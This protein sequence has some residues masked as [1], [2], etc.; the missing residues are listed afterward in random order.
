MPTNPNP[1]NQYFSFNYK[2]LITSSVTWKNVI[3]MAWIIFLAL[4]SSMALGGNFSLIF[5][6]WSETIQTILLRNYRLTKGKKSNI[7]SNPRRL[8]VSEE[9][10]EDCK[11]TVIAKNLEY[12]LI[13]YP[14]DI[15]KCYLILKYQGHFI[16]EVPP[17]GMVLD[18]FQSQS[19]RDINT[20][21]RT[22]KT[23]QGEEETITLTA[24]DYIALFEI[25][26]QHLMALSL[27]DLQTSGNLTVSNSIL[28]PQFRFSDAKFQVREIALPIA[29]KN[30]VTI[31]RNRR[32]ELKLVDTF[33]IVVILGA[34]GSIIFL[35]REH[36]A[37]DGTNNVRLYIYRPLFGIFL[38]IGTFIISISLNGLLS[39][40][41]AADVKTNSILSLAFTA[42][43]LSEPAYKYL[44]ELA[45]RNLENEPP[46]KD[47]NPQDKN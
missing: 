20:I 10:T 35:M 13:I 37:D 17:I 27:D 24:P 45:E 26:E 4:I 12:P 19:W 39:D 15:L 46:K 3:L 47:D 5:E 9:A 30:W 23:P 14:N 43:L 36:I 6:N 8:I 16:E 29:A 38:A 44:T 41:K 1:N 33:F 34:L 11:A 40:E 2:K 25:V 21:R 31:E 28:T 32:N 42:G 7:Y 18:Q 22:R